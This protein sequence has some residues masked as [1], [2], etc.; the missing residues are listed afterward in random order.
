MGS[1]DGGILRKC[2]SRPAETHPQKQRIY[3]VFNTPGMTSKKVA[4][5][6]IF[7]KNRAKNRF[8]V[9]GNVALR[10]TKNDNNHKPLMKG[11][12][13]MSK[14]VMNI[15]KQ[16]NLKAMIAWCEQYHIAYQVL[17]DGMPNLVDESNTTSKPVKPSANAPK[18]DFPTI[19]MKYIGFIGFNDEQKVVRNWGSGMVRSKEVLEKIKY[20]TKKAITEAGGVWDDDVKAYRFKTAKAYKAFKA[21]QTKREQDRA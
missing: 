16:E 2:G 4:K 20:A 13:S 9:C 10:S 19:D 6:T 8:F 21:D 5:M 11:E 18:S 14:L 7:A 3:A 1:F 15:S 17:N 12:K